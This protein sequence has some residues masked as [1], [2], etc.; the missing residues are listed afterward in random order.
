MHA[1]IASCKQ[2]LGSL[3][4]QLILSASFSHA[5]VQLLTRKVESGR[6]PKVNAIKWSRKRFHGARTFGKVKQSERT[7]GLFE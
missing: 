1:Y 3:N 7:N 5:Y 2:V 6:T 4:P